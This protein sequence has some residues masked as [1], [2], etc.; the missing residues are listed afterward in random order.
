MT[1]RNIDEREHPKRSDDRARLSRTVRA[2]RGNWDQREIVP[3]E[4]Y[5]H[6]QAA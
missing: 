1:L 6:R 4:P 2:V 5:G 3:G